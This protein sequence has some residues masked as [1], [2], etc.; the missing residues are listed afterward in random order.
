MDPRHVIAALL[1]FG[2]IGCGGGGAT[3]PEPVAASACVSKDGGLVAR[4]SMLSMERRSVITGARRV[5]DPVAWTRERSG[6][7]PPLIL[8]SHGHYGD[9]IGCTRLCS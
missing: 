5:L 6:C 3:T 1:A 8:F 9:P 4:R 2:A 7:A